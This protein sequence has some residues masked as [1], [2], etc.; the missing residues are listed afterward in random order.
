MTRSRGTSRTGCGCMSWLYLLTIILVVMKAAKLTDLPWWAVTMPAWGPWLLSFFLIYLLG[1][2][3]SLFRSK[4]RATL[5]RGRSRRRSTR[6]RR[7]SAAPF[8]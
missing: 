8:W 7:R 2:S 6:S 1:I 4:P 5:R 3:T